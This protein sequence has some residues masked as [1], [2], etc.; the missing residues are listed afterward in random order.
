[1]YVSYLNGGDCRLV[2]PIG[3]GWRRADG[4]GRRVYRGDSTLVNRRAEVETLLE[5]GRR[6]VGEFGDPSG[7]I[8]VGVLLGNSVQSLLEDH[9]TP[10]VFGALVRLAISGLELLKL[11]S[12]VG[13]S[14]C[15][16]RSGSGGLASVAVGTSGA[17]GVVTHALNK[18]MR[19]FV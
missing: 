7:V 6:E 3:R 17:F 8:S 13:G 19:V 1:M 10:V 11:L 16:C 14:K 9:R 18:W 4:N 15:E 2:P 12:A 5:F